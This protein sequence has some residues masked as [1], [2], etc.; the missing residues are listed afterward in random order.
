MVKII[1][2]A[3]VLMILVSAALAQ[4]AKQRSIQDIF[5][6]SDIDRGQIEIRV[7]LDE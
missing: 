3:V 4:N 6:L 2:S 7:L 5:I 1:T